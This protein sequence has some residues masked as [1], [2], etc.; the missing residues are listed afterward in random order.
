[1]SSF[2]IGHDLHN[3]YIIH[4]HLRHKIRFLLKYHS[5]IYSILD[6]AFLFSVHIIPNWFSRH[7][8]YSPWQH[9]GPPI[10][11][12]IRLSC[13]WTIKFCTTYSFTIAS[14]CSIQ[15]YMHTEADWA[16]DILHIR[17]C[18]MFNRMPNFRP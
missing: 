3:I 15:H 18:C 13:L 14:G 7:P 16:Q 11:H 4:I 1:M 9:V 8:N 10:S 5:V 12:E 6:E 17:K 2:R